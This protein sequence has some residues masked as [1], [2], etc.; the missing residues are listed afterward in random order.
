MP[1]R[2]AHHLEPPL[3][4]LLDDLPTRLMMKRDG[5]DPAALRRMIHALS[6]RLAARQEARPA[7]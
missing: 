3:D 4:E 2:E 6:R 1:A 7:S 5:V